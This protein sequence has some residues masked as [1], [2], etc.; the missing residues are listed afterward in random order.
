M[1]RKLRDLARGQEC[2][3]RLHEDDGT[4]ICN[5]D[6][7]TVVLCH[8]RRGHVAGIA[9]KPPDIVGVWGCCNCHAVID[10]RATSNIS[11]LDGDILSGLCRTLTLVSKELGLG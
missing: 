2:Q 8:I 4:P 3:L 10:G 1:G 5:F 6:S 7:S 9:K 11:N